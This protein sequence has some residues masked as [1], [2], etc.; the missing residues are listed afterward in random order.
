MHLYGK[1][2]KPFQSVSDM[3]L[4]LDAQTSGERARALLIRPAGADGD[5]S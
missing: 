2:S 4:R 1:L 3:R 5:D